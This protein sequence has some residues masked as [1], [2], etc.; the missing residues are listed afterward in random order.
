[1]TTQGAIIIHTC[2]LQHSCES[3]C[4]YP[5]LLSTPILSIIRHFTTQ[6]V[7]EKNNLVFPQNLGRS[8]SCKVEVLQ[9]GATDD[10]NFGWMTN[11]GKE[12]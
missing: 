2:H 11:L 12:I 5:S 1:M 4:A 8:N 10:S 3:H 7:K 6:N 9:V